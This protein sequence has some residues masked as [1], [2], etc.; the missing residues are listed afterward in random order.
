MRELLI[1][2]PASVAHDVERFLSS[3]L[4]PPSLYADVYIFALD[5]HPQKKLFVRHPQINIYLF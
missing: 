4:G 1:R 5:L 2:A 3:P